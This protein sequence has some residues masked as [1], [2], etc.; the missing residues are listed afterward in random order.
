MSEAPPPILEQRPEL[1]P[2]LATL[3]MQCLE[4]D[5]A[6]AASVGQ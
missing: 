3:V 4:K 5:E 6:K 2:A 1:P